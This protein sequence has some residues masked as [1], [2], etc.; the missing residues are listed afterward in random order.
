[1]L[2]ISERAFSIIAMP[3]RKQLLT[4][5]LAIVSFIAKADFCWTELEDDI[6]YADI[7]FVG[8]V[9]VSYKNF[10][11]NGQ[12]IVHTNFIVQKLYKGGDSSI[13]YPYISILGSLTSSQI[14][15]RKDST[16]LVFGRLVSPF[17]S[18]YK[19][20]LPKRYYNIYWTTDCS[21]TRLLSESSE[22][23]N[24]LGE[25]RTIFSTDEI[26][27]I[28]SFQEDW[29]KRDFERKIDTARAPIIKRLKEQKEITTLYKRSFL[30][31]LTLLL[32]AIIFIVFKWLSRPSQQLL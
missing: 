9:D 28:I 11:I 19:K 4:L 5:F 24:K 29:L 20:E 18:P 10:W 7:I 21:N 30:I 13:Y 32:L 22:A 25:P 8:K 17:E 1:M 31:S 16:Y 14:G 3:M 2:R 26:Q 27:Q 12:S 15:F 23:L 6:E